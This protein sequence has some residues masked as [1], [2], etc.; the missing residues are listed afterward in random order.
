MGRVECNGF[1]TSPKPILSSLS[2]KN[3]SAQLCQS[4]CSTRE[5]SAEDDPRSTSSPETDGGAMHQRRISRSRSP[6]NSCCEDMLQKARPKPGSR[7]AER[8]TLILNNLPDGFSRDK[9]ANLLNSHGYA[10]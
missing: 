10:K 8:T 1:R 6:T 7:P 3:D 9:V 4:T 5:P 2:P